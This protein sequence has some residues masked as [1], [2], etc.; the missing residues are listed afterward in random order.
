MAA[1]IKCRCGDLGALNRHLFS[2]ACDGG[3]DCT[4]RYHGYLYWGNVDV[5]DAARTYGLAVSLGKFATLFFIAWAVVLAVLILNDTSILYTSFELS[6]AG[7]T[8]HLVN[9]WYYWIYTIFF[10]LNISSF[11]V[12]T[13][14][15][16]LKAASKRAKKGDYILLGGLTI[17]GALSAVFDLILPIMGRYDL[18]WVGPLSVSISMFGVFL[19]DFE[20]SHRVGV[21]TV[22]AGDGIYGYHVGWRGDLYDSVLFDFYGV[23]QDS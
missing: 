7:N 8:V 14:Y 13:Y 5:D 16:A 17:S 23:V 10:V 9:G 12:A 4:D 18:I 21:S 2:V 1:G 3:R 20:I 15:H 6:N 22:A 19:C 11:L